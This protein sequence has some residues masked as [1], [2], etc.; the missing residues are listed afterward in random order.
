MFLCYYRTNVI[1]V[2]GNGEIPFLL[3]MWN[4]VAGNSLL[5]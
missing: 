2:F 5:L 3:V 1:L 4:L